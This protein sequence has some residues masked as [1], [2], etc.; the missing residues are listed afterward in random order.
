MPKSPNPEPGDL[1]GL[2][3][4]AS[5]RLFRLVALYKVVSC[6][7]P[8]L[9]QPCQ[10]AVRIGISVPVFQTSSGLRKKDLS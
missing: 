6:L 5:S 10:E 9:S 2:R 1:H 8:L 3:Y 4:S 7:T